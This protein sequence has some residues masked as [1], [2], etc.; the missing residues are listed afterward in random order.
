MSL[1]H[2]TTAKNPIRCYRV[3]MADGCCR[4]VNAAFDSDAKVES[5]RLAKKSCA[6]V[7]MSAADVRRATRVASCEN[8]SRGFD[9]DC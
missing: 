8:L 1:N 7:A 3:F 9:D 4:L 2:P 5:V 6:G